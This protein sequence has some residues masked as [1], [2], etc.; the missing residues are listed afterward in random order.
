MSLCSICETIGTGGSERPKHPRCTGHEPKP[1]EAHQQPRETRDMTMTELNGMTD[2]EL[3]ARL[4]LTPV[5][6]PQT[7][8]ERIEA[9]VVRAMPEPE[10]CGV[11]DG[12]GCGDCYA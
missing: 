10:D 4:G 9:H 12:K 2:D 3:R 11:C 8:E 1:L 6:R 7:M 5:D